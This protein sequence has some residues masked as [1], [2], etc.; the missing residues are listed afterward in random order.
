[1]KEAAFALLL[2]AA[3]GCGAGGAHVA[4]CVKECENE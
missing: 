3:A 1:M 4:F 2:L